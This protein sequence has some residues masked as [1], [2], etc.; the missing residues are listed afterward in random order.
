MQPEEIDRAA[1]AAETYVEKSMSP[2]DL[3]A[4]I[5]LGNAMTVNQ[6]FTSNKELLKRSL[7]ALNPAA[8]QGFEEGLTGTTE[9]TPDTA[10]PFTVD[11]TEYNI[12]NTDRRLEALR[13]IAN[14]LARIEEKKSLIYFSSGMDRTGIENQSEL[15]AAI[16]T[17]VRANLSIYTMDLRKPCR[18]GEKRK[19]RVSG[20]HR[21]SLERR[22]LPSM[23]PISPPRKRW[24]LWQ[25]IRVAA[26]TW[27]P[28]TSAGSSPAFRKT[29]PFTICSVITARIQHKMGNIAASR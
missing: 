4:V 16:N 13:S 7:Q 1:T 26:L 17:A 8:G 29:R 24:L 14:K 22:C 23:I 9:A 27:I 12:F 18:R 25:R 2:A 21:P 28:M 10:Q 20:A 19:M 11:D 15:R 3:V 5:S 6:D